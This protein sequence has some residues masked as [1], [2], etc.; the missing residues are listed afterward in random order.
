MPEQ[1]PY[2]HE[3]G[4]DRTIRLGIALAEAEGVP[5]SDAAARMIASQYHAGASSAFYSFVSTGAIEMTRLQEEYVE[6]YTDEDTT[7]L[8]K[9]RLDY[10]GDYLLAKGERPPVEGWENIWASE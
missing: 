10:L 2:I 6:I 1:P 9:H 3:S 4:D 7:D 8:D 5:I